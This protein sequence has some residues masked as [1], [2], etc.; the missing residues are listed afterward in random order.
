MVKEYQENKVG[1]GLFVLKGK[2]VQ[3]LEEL[4]KVTY[5]I[6]SLFGAEKIWTP[7]HLS[8]V[9]SK[10]TGYLDSFSNQASLIHDLDGHEKGMCSPTVCYHCY[11]MLSNKIHTDNKS[12]M[13]TGKCTRI[14]EE[15]GDTLERMF[16]FTISEIVFVGT[17]EYCE[18]SLNKAMIYTEQMLNQLGLEYY[19]EI[20]SDP[21]FGDKSELKEKV[22]L[23]SGSKIEIRG[24][25]PNEDR[26]VALGSFNLHGKKFVD[27]FNIHGAEY[28]ACFGWG[29]ERF[30]DLCM[31]QKSNM[32]FD[33][34]FIEPFELSSHT[35]LNVINDESAWIYDDKGT[36]WFSRK[37]I[38]EYKVQRPGLGD[39][40]YEDIDT[41]EKLENRKD[42]IIKGVKE[43]RLINSEYVDDISTKT[44]LWDYDV[45]KKR[46]EDGHSLCAMFHNKKMIQWNWWFFNE[47]VFYDHEW[48][49]KIKLPSDYSYGGYWA[50][51]PE[52]RTNRKHG[53]LIE[54]FFTYI[55]NYL[56]VRNI[57]YDLAYVDGWNKKAISIHRKMGYIGYDWLNNFKGN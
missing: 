35:R 39:V 34:L 1:K 40:V 33:P 15:G 41:I 17:K 26:S 7:S 53:K 4:E 45:A 30:V 8:M 10:K 23:N 57:K 6:G 51:L 52:Y 9:N 47:F 54:N 38:H 55:T 48:D 14:E 11:S 49:V 21:F 16:N 28:T 31:K 36:Y 3:Y 43:W 24:K 13:M 29:L 25:V 5:R 42:E 2:I 56:I 44:W 46:I 22:Q 37:P 32:D 50:C 18:E 12:Y 19:F 20:A 27:K